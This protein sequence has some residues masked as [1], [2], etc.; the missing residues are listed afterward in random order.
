M[1]L[2][3]RKTC[4]VCGST[5]LTR[6]IDLGDQYLQGSFVKPGK[7]LPPRVRF[8]RRSFD[9]IPRDEHAC[10][11]LQM[12]H[13]VPPEILYSAYWYRS[14]TNET[15]RGHLRGI[16]EEA[17][18]IVDNDHARARHRLQ[19]RHT[20]RRLSRGVLRYRHRPIRCRAGGQRAR[21]HRHSASSSLGRAEPA[22]CMENGATS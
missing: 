14:G 18:G 15:M 16:A 1:H 12:E 20:S 21:H 9:V 4:R 22:C 2:V 17:S 10:G 5:A 3:H 8:Q 13:T 6:V 19:R 11:L 7:E